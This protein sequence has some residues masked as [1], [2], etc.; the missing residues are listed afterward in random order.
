[1]ETVEKDDKI[2]SK[3]LNSQNK[4]GLWLVTVL[5]KKNKTNNL[6]RKKHSFF[7]KL[8]PKEHLS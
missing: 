5:C 4:E 8:I 3:L 1:M 6:F 2:D 7:P